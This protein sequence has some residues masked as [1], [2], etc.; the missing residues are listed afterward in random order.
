MIKA[1]AGEIAPTYIAA[2]TLV[3]LPIIRGSLIPISHAIERI[4]TY[5]E[6]YERLDYYRVS[7]F[8][9]GTQN[10]RKEKAPISPKVISCQKCSLSI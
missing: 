3:T 7:M 4:P 2:F 9:T 8:H 5:Q 6:F 10:S 1:L